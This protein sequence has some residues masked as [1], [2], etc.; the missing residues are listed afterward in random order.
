[1]G[2]DISGMPTAFIPPPSVVSQRSAAEESPEVSTRKL[3][4]MLLD[5]VSYLAPPGS[6]SVRL[7]A[8][9]DDSV[10]REK[11]EKPDREPVGNKGR[12]AMPWQH[13][14]DEPGIADGHGLGGQKG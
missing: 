10:L 8:G 11:I 13:A 7:V 14:D 3:P 4:R 1:M 2:L 12:P 6:C 9:Q 5:S